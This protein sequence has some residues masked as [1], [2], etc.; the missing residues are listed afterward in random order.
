MRS[1]KSTRKKKKGRSKGKK[2]RR[3]RG[4]KENGGEREDCNQEKRRRGRNGEGKESEEGEEDS[5]RRKWGT[6]NTPDDK[7]LFLINPR[8]KQTEL[9]TEKNKMN[10]S[11]RKT[12]WIDHREKPS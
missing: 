7:N 11:Q 1:V 3:K 10:L 12:D 4:N 5:R 9:I 6:F 8:E 2:G